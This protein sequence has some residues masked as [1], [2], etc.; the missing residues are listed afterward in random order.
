MSRLDDLIAQYCPDGVEYYSIS[1]IFN[2]RNGYTPSKSNPEYWAN[3]TIP[4]FRLEDI[5]DNGRILSDSIQHVNESAVKGELFPENSLIVATSA[6]I[7][8]HALITVKSLANQ[9]FT[10]LMLKDSW[11]EKYDINFLF[12]YCYKLDEWCKDHLTQGSFASVDMRLFYSFRFP[13]P[14][15]PVQQEIVRILDSFTQLTSSLHDKILIEK[16]TRTKQFRFYCEKILHA[17]KYVP[18]SSLGV[19]QSG[20]TPSMAEKRFWENG[21]IPWISSKDMKSS[22][23]SDTQD[24]ITNTAVRL[25]PMNLVPAGSVAIVARSGILKHTLPV[26][27]VPFETTVN[28]DIKILTV[29]DGVSARYV[30]FILQILGEDILAFAKKQGGTVDSLDFQKFLSYSIPL[31]SLDIQLQITDKFEKIEKAFNSLSD[32]LSLETDSRR[33]QYEYYR[34]KLLTF[35]KANNI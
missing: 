28:Q 10:Y 17:E 15:I 30:S 31:P 21:S 13:A 3:G 26:A 19:W 35:K 16:Q 2:T 11:K 22:L 34:N 4:W 1:E 20:K 23:L 33:K 24:H 12:Y 7:G 29:K 5:R 18:I 9:R 14:P 25:A 27:Y 32:N 6:T 8:E